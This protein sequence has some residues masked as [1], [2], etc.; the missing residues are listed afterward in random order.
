M[1]FVAEIGTNHKGNKA[2]AYE[3]VRQAKLAG[4][5][6]AKFQLGHCFEIHPTQ[7]M[8]HA[9]NLWVEELAQWC[10]DLDIEFMASVFSMDGLKLA[11]SVNMRRY[12][13]A[14]PTAFK[15]HGAGSQNTILKSMINEGKTVF[16]TNRAYPSHQNILPIFAVPE[17]PT[18]PSNMEI[19]DFGGKWFG[20]SSHMHGISDKLIAVARGAQYVEAHVTL[21]KTE[22]TIRDNSFAL[23]FEEFG[24]MAKIGRQMAWLLE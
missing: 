14:S 22:E 3:M 11:R 4:A 6:I 8:R 20:Y 1:L 12:K 15:S 2:L 5:D 13:M 18:Y 7:R 24:E 19:P 23:S 16:A 10:E 17:Y 21:D 9:P